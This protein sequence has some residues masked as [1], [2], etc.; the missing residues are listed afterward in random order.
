MNLGILRSFGRYA[1]G[2]SI[3]SKVKTIDEVRAAF[4][5]A[6]ASGKRVAIRA[7]GHSFHDQALHDEDNGRHI[8]IDATKFQSDLIQ[9]APGGLSDRVLL[10]A[11]VKWGDYF[12][13]ACDEASKHAGPVLIPGSMQTGRHATAGGTLSGDCLSRFSGVMGKESRSILS[14]RLLTAAGDLLDVSESIHPELFNAVIGGHGY[15]GFITD[16]TY[17]VF[18]FGLSDTAHTRITIHR[19]FDDLVAMQLQIVKGSATDSL[20]AVSS[21][22][23]TDLIDIGAPNPIKGGVFDSWFAP[24]GVPRHV[25]FPPYGDIDSPG[26]SAIEIAARNEAANAA[27][28]ELLFQLARLHPDDFEND[29]PD[30]LFF[31][32]GNTTAKHRY[33]SQTGKLFPIAQQTFVIPPE[34][35]AAFAAACEDKMRER[36]IRPTES[37][38]LYVRAD[39]CLMSANYKMDGFAVSFAFEPVDA[40]PKPPLEVEELF[41]EFSRDALKLGGRIHLAKSVYAE[42]EVLREMFSPQIRDF[43]A[44]KRHYDPDLILQNTFSDNLFCF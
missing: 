39:D 23:F 3:V 4:S 34:R 11:G 37:D 32:D 2:Q 31:M 12:Q 10:G 21:V 9:F 27:F 17:R 13:A 44:I 30:F 36:S 29:V 25:G 16:A 40:E 38:M 7:G 6:R 35:T 5:D 26:R 20:H 22:W 1:A 19:S 15:L 24:P 33:E 43:E 28:H 42:K 18:P 8:V 14:F 41:R